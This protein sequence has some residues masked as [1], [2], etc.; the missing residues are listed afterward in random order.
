MKLIVAIIK[1]FKITEVK[2]ALQEAGVSRMTV[3]EVKGFGR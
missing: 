3:A 1:P 2:N